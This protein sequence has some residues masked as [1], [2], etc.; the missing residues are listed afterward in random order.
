[1]DRWKRI[2][3]QHHTLPDEALPVVLSEQD[4]HGPVVYAVNAVG[5]ARGIIMG[6]RA[7]D[8]QAIHPDIHVDQVGPDGDRALLER[9]MLWTRRWCPWTAAESDGIVMDV[10]GADVGTIRDAGCD[11]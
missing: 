7:V 6:A 5:V 11:L 2:T 1:M 4:S 10:R 3:A 8:V 9:L